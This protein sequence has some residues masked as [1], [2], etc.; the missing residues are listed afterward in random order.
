[1]KLIGRCTVLV[2]LASFGIKIIMKWLTVASYR[3]GRKVEDSFQ[4]F[5]YS[6]H[7]CTAGT[8]P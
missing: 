2:C 3:R 7:F 1:M 4:V 8:L 6:K 5:L